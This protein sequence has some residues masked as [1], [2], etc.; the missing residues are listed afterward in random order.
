M[1]IRSSKQRSTPRLAIALRADATRWANVS[2][3]AARGQEAGGMTVPLALAVDTEAVTT[4]HPELA[5]ARFDL[6]PLMLE[7]AP[8]VAELGADPDV[9]KTLICDWSTPDRRLAIARG[10]IKRNQTY[11]IWGVVDR[12]GRFGEADG[13]IGFCAVDE[14]LEHIGHGP[15]LYYAFRRETWG[16]G[17]ATEIVGAVLR[18]LF[19]RGDIAA[20]EALVLA[21]LNQASRRL[22]ENLGMRV[23]GR[24]PHVAYA[25]SQCVPTVRYE[26]WRVTMA[27]PSRAL[28]CLEEAAYKIGQFVAEGV[29]SKEAVAASLSAAAE[30]NG[31]VARLGEGT[32]S[33]IIEESLAAGLKESGLLHYRL[34]RCECPW[35]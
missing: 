25:E 9:A 18:H 23:V 28:S 26:V 7:H 32:V 31:L 22:L 13:F 4:P 24:Y 33:D 16:K 6:K 2:A 34:V 10:W 27:P 5:T 12:D 1:P 21:G 15:E 8:F 14:P 20:V 35:L 11:G 17:V 30:T 3:G 19:Q 29:G